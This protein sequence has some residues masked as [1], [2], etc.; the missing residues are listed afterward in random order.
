MGSSWR[1]LKAMLRKNW[2]LKIRHPYV[3][4]AE[5]FLPAVVMLMLIGVRTQ[6]DTKIHPAQPYI[7]KEMFVEVGKGGSPSFAQLLDILLAKSEYL[8]FAPDTKETRTMINLMS[9]KFPLLK[10]VSRVYKDELELETYI[11]SNVYG[12]CFQY[13]NCSNPKIKGAV[14]FHDQGPDTFDYSIRLNHSWAFSGFP[15]VKTIMDV[16]GPYVDDLEL[17][18][19]AIPILQYSFSGFFTLQQIIDSFIIFAAQ[20]QETSITSEDN[21]WH[22]QHSLGM[23]W[24]MQYTPSTIRMAPFPTREYTDDEFQS[25]IKTVMGVLYVFITIFMV[26]MPQN[27]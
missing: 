14:V 19:Q 10:L 9:I 17:G 24:M 23:S 11:R 26:Y 20:Q 16:N 5:I 8:A 13:K 15:D 7:Q 6:V 27:C 12:S 18:V 21:E 4:C 1:Q 22:R 25:I 2:L 3:T